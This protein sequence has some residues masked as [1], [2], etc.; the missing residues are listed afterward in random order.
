MGTGSTEFAVVLATADGIESTVG[1]S[2]HTSVLEAAERAGMILPSLCRNGTCGACNAQVAVGDYHFGEHSDTALGHTPPPGA[3]LLC[4][5]YPRSDCRIDLAYDRSRIFDAPPS[6]HSATITALETVARATMRLELTLDPGESAGAQFDPGQ[7]VQV[8]IPGRDDR[9]AY[10]LAN[11]S[12]WD[13]IL[14]LFIR[15]QPGGV[16]STFLTREAAVGTPLLVHAPRGAFGLHEHGMRPRW[17]V[18]GGTGIAP[19]LSMLRRMAEWGDPQPARLY[20][21][22]NTEAEVFATEAIEEL[23][24]A[25]PDF[26][27]EICVW[28]PDDGVAWTGFVGTPVDALRRDLHGVSEH[29]DFYV[30]GPPAMVERVEDALRAAGVLGDRLFV[31]RFSAN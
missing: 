5:T 10:S 14:E 29:P 28:R 13:G 25:L 18:G 23:A 9:R 4:R 1:C 24:A 21:G 20:F 12:N 7:F 2:T 3:V 22:A 30:C 8:Q 6:V 27:A 15:L 19:L 11:T 26:T 16:F 17:F 31:E